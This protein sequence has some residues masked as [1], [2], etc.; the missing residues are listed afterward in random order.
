MIIYMARN[1]QNGK[2]YIGKTT[3]TLEERRAKH[4]SEIGKSKLLFHRAL[5]KYGKDAFVWRVLDTAETEEELATLE[6][7]YID[8]FATSCYC[9]GYNLTHG[10][11]GQ[12][13]NAVTRAKI[14]Q[15]SKGNQYFLGK[16]HTPETLAKMSKS[17]KNR[18]WEYTE[19][20]RK[21]MSDSHKGKIPP[22]KGKKY[23]PLTSFEDAPRTNKCAICDKEFP[24]RNHL[25]TYCPECKKNYNDNELRRMRKAK[26]PT[27]ERPVQLKPPKGE[28]LKTA[29]RP[30]SFRCRCRNCGVLFASDTAMRWYCPECNKTKPHPHCQSK[31]VSKRKWENIPIVEKLCHL[32]GE[33]MQVKAVTRTYYCSACIASFSKGWAIKLNALQ[34]AGED[35]SRHMRH[36]NDPAFL[37]A[38][39]I[40]QCAECGELFPAPTCSNKYCPSCKEA[41]VKE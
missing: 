29:R 5:K 33:A 31:E 17:Q 6:M 18:T 28:H 15:K 1:L 16:K 4:E 11:E 38:K 39:A 23:M 21:K 10:G 37:T 25:S 2:I 35:I 34:K 12:I 7:L 32:C 36:R 13:P 26:D 19:E 40:K 14:G 9:V 8:M 3:K 20:I 41:L 27:Y 24:T 30:D 22:M